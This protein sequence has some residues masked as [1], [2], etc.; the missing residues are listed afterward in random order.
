MES[1]DSISKR[2]TKIISGKNKECIIENDKYILYFNHEE[3]NED[4]LFRCKF[5][6]D[7]N[8]KCKAFVKYNQNNELISYD[9]QHLCVVYEKKSFK[10]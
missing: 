8:I 10:N 2:Y 1:L 6:K 4:R 9:D 3:K 5:Y 7:T